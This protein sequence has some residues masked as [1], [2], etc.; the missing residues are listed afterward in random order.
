[1]GGHLPVCWEPQYNKREK[2]GRIFYF[3]FTNWKVR[4]FLP[5]DT[6]G[7]RP[8]TLGLTLVILWFSGL[9]TE[10]PTPAAITEQRATLPMLCSSFP[11][12]IYSAHDGHMS[13][14]LSPSVQPLLPLLCPQVHFYVCVSIPAVATQSSQC[15]RR[16]QIIL[17][18]WSLRDHTIP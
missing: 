14:L 5:L 6:D 15:W 1:M 11:L 3:P 9:W 16:M 8:F 4:L 2:K 17:L 13:V 12:A 7:S 10:T 18:V